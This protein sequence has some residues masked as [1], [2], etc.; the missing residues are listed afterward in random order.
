MSFENLLNTGKNFQSCLVRKEAFDLP[1][2]T[3]SDCLL[4]SLSFRIVWKEAIDQRVIVMSTVALDHKKVRT[5]SDEV[6][7]EVRTLSTL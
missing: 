4:S 7:E 1:I 2:Q 3:P 6:L 5:A